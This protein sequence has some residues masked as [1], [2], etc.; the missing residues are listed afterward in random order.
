MGRVVP[1]AGLPS[2]ASSLSRA[3]GWL[4]GLNRRGRAAWPGR[5]VNCCNC[6]VRDKTS[7]IGD[8]TV[9]WYRSGTLFLFDLK[10]PLPGMNFHYS[11]TQGP[12]LHS[13]VSWPRLGQSTPRLALHTQNRPAPPPSG[14]RLK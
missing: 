8:T 12:T 9:G 10:N 2:R 11:E 5:T 14:Y 3:S 7:D 4:P 13:P 1:V 6:P